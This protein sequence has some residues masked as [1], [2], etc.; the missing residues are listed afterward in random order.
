MAAFILI[1]LFPLLAILAYPVISFIR[2][3]FYPKPIRKSDN[4]L[5]PVSIIIACYN[6]EDYIRQKILA[7]LNEEEWIEG[8][9]IIVV[10]GGSTDRTNEILAGFN[11]H[12][13][14]KI[15]ISQQQLSKISAVNKAVPAAG[16]SLL[17]FS[18]CRQTMKRG[19]VKEM[20]HNFNDPDI[21]TVAAV[22]EDP[23]L[24]R[25][26]SF[27]RWAI[28]RVVYLDSQ[29]GSGLNVYGALYAQRRILFCEFPEDQ[30]FDDLCV[31]S[32]T[33]SQ[34][35]RLIQEPLAVI[36]DVPF[37]S[38]Y[39]SERLER[40]TR[41]LLTFITRQWQ[42]L[43][44]IGYGNLIRLLVFKYAKLLL[45]FSLAIW[46][47]CL[48]VLLFSVDSVQLLVAIGLVILTALI[49]RKIRSAIRLFLNINFHFFRALAGYF[50][51]KQTTTRWERLKVKHP[52]RD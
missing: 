11:D 18:D 49:F 4:Y 23:K 30:I 34:K 27:F 32:N 51:L 15:I 45:P 16:N 25:R 8:S 22:L 3:K 33:L 19:S 13:S 5:L 17:V 39:Y 40:L 46:V 50:F 12:P 26:Q 7:F 20:V 28:N 36:Y 44:K 43:L 24:N 2:Y 10:S 38:Y 37:S 48:G 6:E 1:S 21:G 31:I 29:S 42:T 9:E 52:I 47:C 41:G 35:K 14:V